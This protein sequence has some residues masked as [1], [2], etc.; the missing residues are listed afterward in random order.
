MTLSLEALARRIADNDFVE[1]GA[2]QREAIVRA[3]ACCVVIEEMDF[4][5]LGKVDLVK[6]VADRLALWRVKI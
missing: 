4:E 5:Q 1:L 6:R 2:L 3:L